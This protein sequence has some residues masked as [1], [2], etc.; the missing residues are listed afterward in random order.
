[1][2][3]LFR[4][5]PLEGNDAHLEAH[6]IGEVI[7]LLCSVNPDDQHVF[8]ARRI[9]PRFDLQDLI[10]TF[11]DPQHVAI[12]LRWM[13]GPSPRVT[14]SDRTVSAQPVTISRDSSSNPRSLRPCS[15]TSRSSR[16]PHSSRNKRWRRQ[17]WRERVYHFRGT[18][19]RLGRRMKISWTNGKPSSRVESQAP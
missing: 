16:I 2:P 4:K 6:S 14:A 17:P 13:H 8:P 3:F 5:L 15:S 18:A 19:T 12:R 11:E 10:R 7:N 1:M 9:D